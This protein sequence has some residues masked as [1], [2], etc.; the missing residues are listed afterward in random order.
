MNHHT[1]GSQISEE[2]TIDAQE[3]KV[4]PAENTGQNRDRGARHHRQQTFGS[5]DRD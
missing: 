1:S 4:V 2:D 5:L 3:V